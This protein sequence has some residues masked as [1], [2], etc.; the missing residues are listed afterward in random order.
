M[1]WAVAKRLSRAGTSA[2]VKCEGVAARRNP[3]WEGR[4]GRGE[5]EVGRHLLT[6]AYSTRAKRTRLT[7]T[8]STPEYK[9]AAGIRDRCLLRGVAP[10]GS[11]LGQE[12]Q[13]HARFWKAIVRDHHFVVLA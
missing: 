7:N 2:K 10:R 13:V 6:H 8:K 12:E 1:R 3:G 11:H 5:E 9:T 4:E